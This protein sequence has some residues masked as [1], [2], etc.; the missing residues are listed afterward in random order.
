VVRGG[1]TRV[2]IVR[3]DFSILSTGSGYRSLAGVGEDTLFMIKGKRRRG[4]S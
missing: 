2:V 4:R 1:G 3:I